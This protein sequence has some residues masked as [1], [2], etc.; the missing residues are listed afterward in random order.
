M[1]Q[2]IQAAFLDE[3]EK[4][5][6][7]PQLLR[8]ASAKA[9]AQIADVART[10]SPS[11]MASMR[12]RVAQLP[13][14]D[15]AATGRKITNLQANHAKSGTMEGHWPSGASQPRTLPVP[16]ARETATVA[17]RHAGS[18]SLPAPKMRQAKMSGGRMTFGAFKS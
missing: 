2:T 1:N 14:F 13:R 12:R 11:D 6:L 10:G 7:S 17:S 9:G 3:M 15:R 4:L 18:A 5:A 8:R 16:S